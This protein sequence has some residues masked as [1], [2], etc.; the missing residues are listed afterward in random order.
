MKEILNKQALPFPFCPGCGHTKITQEIANTLEQLNYSPLECVIVTDIGCCGIIDRYFNTHTFHGLHGRV[1]TYA[2]GLKLARPELKVI[3]VMG[4]GGAGIGGGHLIAAARRNIGITVIVYNNFNFGMTGGQQSVTTPLGGV[5]SSCE[6]GN[7]DYPMDICQLVATCRGNWTARTTVYDKEMPEFMKQAISQKGFSLLDIWDICV[8]YYARRNK[9]DKKMLDNLINEC[10]FKKGVIYTDNRPEYCE[11][12][13]K[14]IVSK[15]MHVKDRTRYLEVKFENRLT[16]RTNIIIAGSAGQRIRTAGSILGTA[17]IIS[18]LYAT[19]KDDFPITVMTGHSISEIILD[20]ERILYTGIKRPDFLL[21]LS[22]DGLNYTTS[23]IQRMPAECVILCDTTISPPPTSAQV[24][25]M[26]FSQGVAK[27]GRGAI[28]F[29]ALGL[30]LKLYPI[31]PVEAL[32][33]AVKVTLPP[34]LV[35]NNLEAIDIG[36]SL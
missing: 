32:K 22:K 5:T 28:G 27:V 1:I 2:T 31:I 18:G 26:P 34:E 23:L 16:D 24:K 33:E 17:G 9:V 6:F 12:Y 19:Q 11:A 20:K 14:E 8:A 3:A 7:I 25:K 4:D 35:K 21:V 10:G 36:L 13:Y 30:F 15:A 29:I